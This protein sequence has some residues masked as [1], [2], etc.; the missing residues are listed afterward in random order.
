MIIKVANP[1]LTGL[2]A[3]G[4]ALLNNTTIRNAAIG[5]GVGAIGGAMNAG[6]G[7]RMSGALK[8][9]LVGGAIGGVGTMGVGVAKG[10]QHG[11]V[12][13]NI[14]QKQIGRI[15]STLTKAKGAFAAAQ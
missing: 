10:V 15:G 7:N 8:G 6:E 5:A 3:G 13:G 11:G 12:A 1:L 14:V 9:G 4:K 2:L